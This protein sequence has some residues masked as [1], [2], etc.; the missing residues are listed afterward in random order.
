[1][2]IEELSS[3]SE[4]KGWVCSDDETRYNGQAEGHIRL[5]VT[6]SNLE[7][8]WHDLS[9]WLDTPLLEV[10][11][12][13]YRHG[14][15]GTGAQDLYLRRGP[16]TIF[17]WDDSKSLRYYGADNGMEIHIKDTDPNSMSANGGL[18]DVSLVEKYMMKDEE[19]DKLK[20]SVRAYK[21]AMTQE[22][23]DSKVRQEYNEKMRKMNPN[24]KGD[25]VQEN[26]ERPPTP[27]NARETYTLGSRCE[28]N[29]GGRRGE[30]AYFGNIKGVEGTY[31]GVKL[32]EPMGQNDGTKNGERY[33][34]APEKYGCFSRCENVVVG[35]FPERDP[36]ADL[37]DEDEI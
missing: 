37:D 26:P 5:N 23:A 8:R 28:V 11:A 18:E 7:Q 16:D 1:M 36:F 12:K 17:M 10:K 34:E 22:P 9:F 2:G 25:Q 6:H 31:I 4:L 3:V 30:V 13:L 35:D 27:I 14:G 33:F 29:P 32:D 24:W 21:K 15:T 20:N 19:Y